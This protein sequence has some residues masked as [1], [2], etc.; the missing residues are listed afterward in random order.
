MSETVHYKGKIQLVEKIKDETL[1]EQCKRILSEHGYHELDLYYDSW[2]EMLCEELYERY[3]IVNN[4]I[5][6][7][8]D[9]KN[10]G[11]DYDIFEATKNDD[12]TINYH[13]MYYDGGCSFNEAIEEAIQNME[14]K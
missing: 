1:E 12:K 3:V 2:Y 10:L 4:S 7:V 9:K 8:I 6:K 13:V 5:Y 11:I 14:N